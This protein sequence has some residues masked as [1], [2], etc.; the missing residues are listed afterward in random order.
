LAVGETIIARKNGLRMAQ[1]CCLSQQALP[2]TF[3]EMS[4]SMIL[5]DL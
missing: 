4:T 2:M 1:T 5:N 3:L